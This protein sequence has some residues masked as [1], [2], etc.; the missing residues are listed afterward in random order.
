MR[1]ATVHEEWKKINSTFLTELLYAI[2]GESRISS[3]VV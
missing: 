3:H 2:A 1:G